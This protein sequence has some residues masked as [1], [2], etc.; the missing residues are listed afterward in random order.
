MLEISKLNI[1]AFSAPQIITLNDTLHMSHGNVYWSDNKL[2]DILATPEFR[3][4]ESANG[5]FYITQLCH[6]HEQIRRT[7]GKHYEFP[8]F[9]YPL[10]DGNCKNHNRIFKIENGKS[11][12]YWG[13]KVDLEQMPF[14]WD[15]PHWPL[16]EQLE[17]FRYKIQFE[18]IFQFSEGI[19]VNCYIKKLASFKWDL[20]VEL[21]KINDQWTIEN[22]SNCSKQNINS[23]INIYPT[24]E[25]GVNP[26]KLRELSEVVRHYINN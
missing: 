3:N 12:L 13:N 17:Y 6:S 15:S 1:E 2:P 7:G 22:L 14:F 16:G 4:L 20:D 23:T 24:G 8:D 9:G 5:Y 18:T 10:A 21:N 11:Y 26:T 19:T 25:D